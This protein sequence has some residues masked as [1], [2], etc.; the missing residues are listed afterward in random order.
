MPLSYNEERMQTS[1]LRHLLPPSGYTLVAEIVVAVVAL[2]LLNLSTLSAPLG[3]AG[4]SINASPFSLWSQVLDKLLSPSQHASIQQIL[5][6]ILWG[7]VGALIY[8]FVF[9]L[10]QFFIRARSSLQQGVSLIQTEHS[11]GAMHYFASLHDFFIKLVIALLGAA[12]ILTGALIC[13]AIA[14]QQLSAGLDSS[15]PASLGNFAIALIGA[16]LAVRVIAV[17]VS[18]LSPR[19]RD[20]YNA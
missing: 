18:L 8:I 15:F 14:S 11:Q 17:G 1:E 20:W 6:F 2:V 4:S 13:F 12:A 7:I 9:R 19:F 3:G 5:L 10:L 16:F